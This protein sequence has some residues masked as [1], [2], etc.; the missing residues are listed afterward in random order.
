MDPSRQMQ[1]MARDA[2]AAASKAGAQAAAVVAERNR[3]VEV[4][5]R[6]GRLDTL[7]E[8][9]TRG[10]QLELYVDGR[11]AQ[12]GTS[13]LRPEAL[14][15]FVENAIA[16]TRKLEP[17][18]FRALPGSALYQGQAKVALDLEDPGYAALTAPARRERAQAA[19]AGARQVQGAGA[20]LSVTTGVQDVLSESFRVHTDGFEGSRRSTA[21]W[22]SA[23]VSVKDPDGRRPED[24]DYAGGRYASAVPAAGEV[25]RK[26]ATRALSRLGSKKGQSGAMTMV[27]DAR[28]AGRF[29]STF[30]QPLSGMALQQ[31]QSCL[32]GKLGQA[33]GSALLD[34][35]DDP[36]VPRGLGSRLYDAE[37][38]A[39]KRFPVFEKGVLRNCYVDTYYGRKMKRD[40]T[41]RNL[42]NLA[43]PLGSRDQAGL[44]ADAKDAILVSGFL[45]GNS[46]GTTGDF[47]LGV[48]GY[49]VRGGAIAEPVSE[50]N[51]SGNL[52]E[53][54]KRL[55]AVGNDP[56]PYSPMR[57]PTLVFEGIQFAGT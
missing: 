5:W 24:W 28:A 50:M 44:L 46:N 18:P 47:S 53:V 49:R 3:T 45:G 17:D 42:S 31:K 9:T 57:T 15:Q 20:I 33:V 19:E 25:G 40:P 10:L 55:V 43:W 38:M 27:I 36:L 22:A 21:F 12:V 37:G 23:E 26:A 14:V 7:K 54:W 6:D 32:E 16:L 29:Y 1:E 56:Y 41:T 51:V 30:T 35:S 13:D 48:Q 34:V 52:L 2:A 8:A 11:W 39:A 4:Q